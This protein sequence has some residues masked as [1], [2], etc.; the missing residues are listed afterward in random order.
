MIPTVP[1]LVPLATASG[2]VKPRVPLYMV[3][4]AYPAGETDVLELERVEEVVDWATVDEMLDEDGLDDRA[5]V[6][7]EVTAVELLVEALKE[8]GLDTETTEDVELGVAEL[9]ALVKTNPGLEESAET[10]DEELSAEIPTLFDTVEALLAGGEEVVDNGATP[11]PEDPGVVVPLILT[12]EGLGRG[13]GETM[14][15]VT[16]EGSALEA[17]RLVVWPLVD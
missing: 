12:D 10:P 3:V 8:L 5:E 9:G 4:V 17:V 7:A 1:L 16:L 11:V 14:M 2:D 15:L 6:L 13:T